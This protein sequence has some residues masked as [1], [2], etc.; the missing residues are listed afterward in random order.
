MKL[1]YPRNF[2]GRNLPEYSSLDC[3]PGAIPKGQEM[4]YIPGLKQEDF[5]ELNGRPTRPAIARAPEPIARAPV[6][7][8]HCTQTQQASHAQPNAVRRFLTRTGNELARLAPVGV[9]VAVPAGI[10]AMSLAANTLF[11]STIPPGTIFGVSMLSTILYSGVCLYR[12]ERH[13]RN[14]RNERQ[15]NERPDPAPQPRTEVPVEQPIAKPSVLPI[16]PRRPNFRYT[17]DPW[18]EPT[19]INY[20]PY[21][22]CKKSYQE[23]LEDCDTVSGGL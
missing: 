18:P 20:T 16:G 13:E 17:P 8:A 10:T 14:E 21:K 12:N 4:R 11:G 3:P 6:Q 5:D 15:T 1:I 9:L 7:V 22:P 2:Q 19:T 23:L